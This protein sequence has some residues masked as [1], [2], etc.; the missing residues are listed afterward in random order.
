KSVPVSEVE[1]TVQVD[2]DKCPAVGLLRL[3]QLIPAVPACV[4]AVV[5]LIQRLPQHPGRAAAVRI[6]IDEFLPDLF[7]FAIKLVHYL[8][9]AVEGRASKRQPLSVTHSAD[10]LHPLVEPHPS[11]T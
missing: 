4:L 9:P 2:L 1:L 10:Q 8:A 11:Q 3:V 7:E 5:Q 6:E